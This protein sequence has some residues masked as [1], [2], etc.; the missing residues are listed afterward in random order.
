MKIARIFPRKTNATPDDSLV[1]FGGP[2]RDL[3]F[4][5]AHISVA[6]TYDK[7]HKE[8]LTG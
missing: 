8:I 3:D 4:D 2:P 1:F 5:N 7:K 6:F